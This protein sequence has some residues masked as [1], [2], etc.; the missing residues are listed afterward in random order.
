MTYLHDKVHLKLLFTLQI[1]RHESQLGLVF[2]FFF[3]FPFSKFY[4][5][6]LIFFS[7]YPTKITRTHTCRSVSM[8]TYFFMGL[9]VKRGKKKTTCRRCEVKTDAEPCG[10]L[11]RHRWAGNRGTGEACQ[12]DQ[13]ISEVGAGVLGYK[14]QQV[15]THTHVAKGV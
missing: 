1:N 14:K 15:N 9:N 11:N 2:L 8:H 12:G 13:S 5:M 7:R 10:G 4:D 3:F 6:I